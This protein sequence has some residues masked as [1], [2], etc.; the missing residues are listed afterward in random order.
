M[1]NNK[2]PF[3]GNRIDGTTGMTDSGTADY[4]N[5]VFGKSAETPHIVIQNNLH[6]ASNGAL[7]SAASNPAHAVTMNASQGDSNNASQG[8]LNKVSQG[9][10]MNVSQEASGNDMK[11]TDTS[12]N[13]P[14]NATQNISYNISNK[15]SNKA[16]NNDIQ[17][18][19][20]NDSQNNKFNDSQNDN[21]DDSKN[22]R[23]NDSQN[24]S[25]VRENKNTTHH[26]KTQA[27][28]KRIA[29]VIIAVI[30]GALILTVAVISLVGRNKSK[31]GNNNESAEEIIDSFTE[32]IPESSEGDPLGAGI[33]KHIID[34]FN[35]TRK[36][37]ESR[38][39]MVALSEENE[40]SF[41]NIDSCKIE[42]NMINV[43]Y[44]SEIGIAKSDDKFYYLFAIKNYDD[45]LDLTDYEYVNR[46]YKD[47][48]GCISCELKANTAD[49]G[50]Y[51]KYGVAVKVDGEYK[52][53]GTPSFITNPGALSKHPDAY[54]TAKS[55]KGILID[56]NRVYTGELED[57]GVAQA[58]INI[59]IS[60]ILGPT[61]NPVFPSIQYNYDGRNYT[62]NG[63]VIAGFDATVSTLTE[64]GIQTTAI[65]L[66]N[67]TYAHPE[68]IHP[69]ARQKNACP[70]YMFNG[71]T[72]D[73]VETIAAVGAFLSE[74][75][76][77]SKHGKVSNWV[78][79]NEINARKEWNYLKYTD[80]DTYTK[81]YAKAYRVFYNAIISNSSNAKVMISLD[82]IWD[83]NR[84]GSQDYDGKD[85]LDCF[86]RYIKEYGNI[87]WALA[88]HPYNIPLTT[89]QTWASSR[90]VS[91][92]VNSYT[93]SMQ[94]IEVLINYL[95]QEDFLGT[96]GKCRTIKITELGYTSTAGENEQAAALAY[97]F[98]KINNYDEIDG[99]LL[100]RETDDPTEIAQGLA[101]G[102]TTQSGKKKKSYEVFKYM[103]TDEWES[104]LD[105]AKSIIGISNWKSIMH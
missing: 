47:G 56:Y 70:Y 80:V 1:D 64:K 104:H 73:G 7:Q 13:A 53:I 26:R 40:N 48:S 31:E 88:Y 30:L 17:N 4:L 16:S 50:L 38:P 103:D 5:S 3:D 24:D 28:N 8:D 89:C 34:A 93:V 22:D 84:E 95:K 12:Y 20:V 6:N 71:S 102:V 41:I 105:F 86:N 78:I 68:L 61:T 60:S 63:M 23:I 74:R 54:M 58:A 49:T 35:M 59:P 18:D 55:K 32:S 101:T 42:G 43:N 25:H 81:E 29:P 82:Q 57:L 46:G 87:D 65:L 90:Y 83:L 96:D 99:L 94:N 33:V 39:A 52:L 2:K 79:A 10:S 75:Y 98:Y 91:H 67:Y 97:A 72:D 21:V 85:V 11:N 15:A 36:A 66:N 44:S 92:N 100:N 76:S 27:V 37:N 62:F 77:G 45:S 51:K 19:N 9:D 14:D 69:D